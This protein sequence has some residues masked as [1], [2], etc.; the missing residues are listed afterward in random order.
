MEDTLTHTHIHIYTYLVR[1]GGVL[2]PVDLEG[3]VAGLVGVATRREVCPVPVCVC[4]CVRRREEHSQNNHASYTTTLHHSLSYPPRR[5]ATFV[6]FLLKWCAPMGQGFSRT[7]A[8][9]AEW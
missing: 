5:D 8:S 2:G 9:S 7:N 6:S 1:V 3:A 4:V